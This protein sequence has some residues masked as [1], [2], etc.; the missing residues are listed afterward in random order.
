VT[1]GLRLIRFICLAL[2][3]AVIVSTGAI[4]LADP[5][6]FTAEKIASFISESQTSIW[7]IYLA[8]SALRGLTLLPSTPLVLA[9]TLLYPHEPWLVLTISLAG[10]LMSSSMIYFFSEA[11]GL[12]E[13]FER[14]K[15][16]A[17][18]RIRRR[19][20]EPAG[21]V[22]VGLWAFFP[23]VPTDVVCYVAG[24]TKMNFAKFI[25][26]VF[27]GEAVLCSIYVFTGGALVRHWF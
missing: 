24:S 6:N 26:A 22:F 13:Y 21:L 27:T 17:V 20:E 10:I 5:G 15:P 11:L 12:T 14:S 16:K 18:A 4:Y 2:W 19:L 7:I 3:A 9:G 25:F 8:M 23:L 1:S